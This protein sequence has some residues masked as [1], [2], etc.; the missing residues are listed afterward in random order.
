M[1]RGVGSALRAISSMRERSVR[2][3]ALI[4][5]LARLGGFQK[6]QGFLVMKSWATANFNACFRRRNAL[7]TDSG[8]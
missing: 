5:V 8:A 1:D 6:S 2:D 3:S 7:L 4:S